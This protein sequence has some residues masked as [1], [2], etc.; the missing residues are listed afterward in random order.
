MYRFPPQPLFAPVGYR[1]PIR[2][3]APDGPLGPLG[4]LA[5]RLGY[6]GRGRGRGRGKGKGKGR[7]RNRPRGSRG[8]GNKRT[9]SPPVKPDEKAE[10]TDNTTSEV[11]DDITDENWQVISEETDSPKTETENYDFCSDMID[12]NSAEGFSA[13]SEPAALIISD[14]TE[15]P[16][17]TPTEEVTAEEA[18]ID[19]TVAEENV[20]IEEVVAS[21]DTQATDESQEITIVEDDTLV[22]NVELVESAKE[23]TTEAKKQ[24]MEA[25][26]AMKV[27]EKPSPTITT[28]TAPEPSS[29]PA[30]RDVVTKSSPYGSLHCEV[31]TTFTW[32]NDM[33]LIVATLE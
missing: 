22:S 29:P 23:Q 9:V 3:R 16:T 33:P 6:P 20:M 14:E 28:I 18:A 21:K 19:E 30:P 25:K 31:T 5:S 17:S 15:V 27:P 11:K 10:V 13:F 32:L 4:P 7:Q 24:T 12:T 1:I 26:E 2:G 8:G